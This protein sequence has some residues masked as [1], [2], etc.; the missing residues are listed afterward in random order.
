M[1]KMK[2]LARSVIYWPHIDDDIERTARSCSSCAEQQNKPPKP[3]NHP[4]ILPERPWSRLHIDHAVNFL[5]TN[6][7]VLVDAYSK[8]PCIRAVT[9]LS[10][11]ATTDVLEQEFSHFGYPHT[12]VTD[13]ASAFLSNEFQAWCQERGITHLSGAPYHP[14]TNGAAERLVQTFKK[15]LIKSALPPKAALLEFLIQYRRTPLEG[16]GLSPSEMLIGR[17]IRTKLDALVPSPAHAAQGRQAKA[18]A[19]EQRHERTRM[20]NITTCQYAVGAPCFALYCC[21]NRNHRSPRWVPAVVVKVFGTRSVNVRVLPR[22]PIWRRHI[23]QL[24][25]RYVVKPES[26]GDVSVTSD[27]IYYDHRPFY[28]DYDEDK[29]PGDDPINRQRV[30]SAEANE[31]TRNSTIVATTQDSQV[32]GRSTTTSEQST[33]DSRVSR[34]RNPR[35]PNDDTYGPHNPRR[36]RRLIAQRQ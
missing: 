20:V 11:K 4:W 2:Q 9:S 33:R 17:Q 26:E 32:P 3:A 21:P 1:Q 16:S 6:W 7:L 13:N 35:L 34:Q 31:P 30:I 23:E 18:A 28:N 14:A 24:R 25:P 36:S 5:G 29:E 8:Y 19:K 27:Q 15:S 22:G 10:S 12:L